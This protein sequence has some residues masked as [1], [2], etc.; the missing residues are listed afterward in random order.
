L[1][2]APKILDN[3]D[4]DLLN[5]ASDIEKKQNKNWGS[6]IIAIDPALICP[7]S[8]F[9]ERTDEMC[10]RVSNAKVLPGSKGARIYLPGERGDELCQRNT[11]KGTV[12]LD[13]TMHEKLLL[14][15]KK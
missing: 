3:N 9:Q 8:E 10:N 14:L 5:Q 15:A 11:E 13:G 6:T 4:E 12:T 7:L 1:E 2:L